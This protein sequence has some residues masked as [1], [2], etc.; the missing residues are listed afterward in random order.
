MELLF[1]TATRAIHLELNGK[2]NVIIGESGAGKTLLTSLANEIQKSPVLRRSQPAPITGNANL[3]REWSEMYSGAVIVL[4]EGK[5][6]L[7]WK[8]IAAVARRSHNYYIICSREGPADIP[9]G[10]NTTFKMKRT[11]HELRM[12]PA[13]ARGAGTKEPKG[14]KRILTEDEGVGHGVVC[15]KTPIPVV[16]SKGKDNLPACVGAYGSCRE[17]LLVLFDS[18]GIGRTYEQ[19]R[20]R[21]AATTS[22]L[23]DSVSFEHEV[24]SSVF[25][26]LSIPSYH[27]SCL[28]YES[29]EAYYTSVLSSILQ[30]LFNA[31][32]SKTS[33]ELISLFVKG[34]GMLH[35]RFVDLTQYGDVSELYSFLRESRESGALHTKSVGRMKLE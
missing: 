15:E 14:F 28:D 16:S 24:L 27:K 18:C 30:Q 3:V 8:E 13:Y 26:R 19:L 11:P 23:Y 29:E 35:G 31:G 12:V 2:F 7:E 22:V 6:L 9:Y 5:S 34:K 17:R 33:A 20:E 10:V 21:A 25:K 32:Y 1:K 4:D